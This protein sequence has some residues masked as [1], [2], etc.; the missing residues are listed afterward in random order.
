MGKPSPVRRGHAALRRGRVSLPNQVYLVTFTTSQRAPLFSDPDCAMSMA[1]AL[2]DRRLWASSE[3][4]AWVL[5][6]D[7]W[8]GLVALGERDYLPSLVQRL[9]ANTGRHVRQADPRVGRVWG[10]GYHDRLLRAEEQLVDA[11]RYLVMNPVRAGLVRRA[12]D[13]PYWDAKWL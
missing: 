6:P 4:L 1:R 7:H 10:S 2:I 12:G 3:L 13:Y 11:A 8:H 9:K 5:M